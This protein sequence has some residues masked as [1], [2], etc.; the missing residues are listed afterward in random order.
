MLVY[1]EWRSI[2]QQ[3]HVQSF[4]LQFHHWRIGVVLIPYVFANEPAGLSDSEAQQLL[5]LMTFPN[6]QDLGGYRNL[7]EKQGC[8]V[9]EAEDTWRFGPCFDRY[10]EMLR[11][12]HTYDA[13][14]ILD[15]DRDLLRALE[16]QLE[17]LAELGHGGKLMQA[18]F[19]AR[20]R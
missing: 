13:L 18:R 1:I 6:L 15:F 10:A 17:F 4:L 16:A 20:R 19:V 3:E 14:E 12:Q 8:E 5:Q 7:V 2:E 9:L 11:T